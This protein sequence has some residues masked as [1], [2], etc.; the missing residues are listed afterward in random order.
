MNIPLTGNIIYKLKTTEEL[1]Y[2]LKD[3]LRKTDELAYEYLR[4]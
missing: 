4:L 1:Y 2:E 3:S